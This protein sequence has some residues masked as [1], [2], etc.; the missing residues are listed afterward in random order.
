MIKCS[1]SEIRTKSFLVSNSLKTSIKDFVNKPFFSF[2]MAFPEFSTDVN[3]CNPFLC[4]NEFFHPDFLR[5][6]LISVP[7]KQASTINN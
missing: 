7:E 2:S 6:C 5:S 4:K 1:S 3:A